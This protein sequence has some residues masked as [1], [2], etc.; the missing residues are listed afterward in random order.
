MTIRQ[1]L[2]ENKLGKKGKV[3]LRQNAVKDYIHSKEAGH[4]F[5]WAD[6]IYSAGYN[7]REYG[8]GWS[9]VKR[10]VQNDVIRIVDEKPGRGKQEFIVVGDDKVIIDK[11]PT[12]TEE[13]FDRGPIVLKETLASEEY[14]ID[15]AKKFAWEHNS[16]SLRGF[17]AT[18]K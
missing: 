11:K 14:I 3:R 12:V 17:I 1:E 5:S 6:L 18:L 7:K 13:P 2:L 4:L 9:F 8:S 15:L 16:D 10:M